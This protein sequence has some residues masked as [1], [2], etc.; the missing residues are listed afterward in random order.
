[1]VLTCH[2][3]VGRHHARSQA[4]QLLEGLVAAWLHGAAAVVQSPSAWLHGTAIV[5]SPSRSAPAALVAASMAA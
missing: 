2:D 1:M 3:L 4:M 5:Q